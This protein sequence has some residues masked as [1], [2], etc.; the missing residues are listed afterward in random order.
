MA[1]TYLGVNVRLCMFHFLKELFTT[2]SAAKHGKDA[3]YMFNVIWI[4]VR[5]EDEIMEEGQWKSSMVFCLQFVII[6]KLHQ[7]HLQET[8][9]S[10]TGKSKGE[11][12]SL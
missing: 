2:V 5:R 3:F 1:V 6:L 9:A 10:S 8:E 4:F 11:V 12:N 7:L